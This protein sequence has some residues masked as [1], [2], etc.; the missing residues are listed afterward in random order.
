MSLTVPTKTTAL[1]A[2]NTA[3]LSRARP[4]SGG[5]GGGRPAWRTAMANGTVAF[6]PG[7]TLASI[8][9][10]N[11]IS[12]NANYPA[13]AQYRGNG[14]ATIV[15]A[16]NG[17]TWDEA[18]CTAWFPLQGGHQDWAGN[19]SYK[20]CLKVASPQ[21]SMLRKPSGWDN[22]ITLNDGQE[23]SGL[24]ADGRVRPGHGYNN[25]LYIPGF[26]PVAMR[27]TGPYIVGSTV[28]RKA[29][30]LNETTGE[31]TVFAADSGISAGYGGS[32]LDAAHNRVLSIDV[33]TSYLHGTDLTTRVTSILL[34]AD[35]Y[36]ARYVKPVVMPSLNMVAFVHAGGTGFPAQI[37]FRDLDS[38]GAIITPT[39]TG[40]FSTG[41]EI[42]GLQGVGWDDVNQRFYLWNNATATNEISTLTPSGNPRT[43]PWVASKRTFTG[44][45]VSAAATNSSGNSTLGRFGYSANL[46]ACYLLNS[47]SEQFHI[48]ATE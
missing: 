11:S 5:G 38:L 7:N 41:L 15:T 45:T 21:F 1:G 6:A 19:E 36:A 28:T 26:G 24:Y 47:V 33:G 3:Y 37:Y 31:M 30:L 39:I 34:Q 25:N 14:F 9:P 32:A 48:F 43:A 2:G 8:N 16:W 18:T 12:T 35:N 17:M 44:V 13:A 46:G 22:S 29:F 40:A 27:V 10:E 42:N 4:G 20:N 23:A